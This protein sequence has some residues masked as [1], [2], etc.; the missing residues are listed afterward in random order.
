MAAVR[1]N[2]N[3]FASNL[4]SSAK[5]AKKRRRTLVDQDYSGFA[6]GSVI[7]IKVKN[8][9]TY[10][11]AEFVLSPSLNMIIGPNGTGKS[12]FVC[13]LCLGLAGSPQLL[14]RQKTIANF[15]KNGEESGV[16]EVTLKG[17]NNEKN[18]TIMREI[19]LNNKSDWY[20]NGKSSNESKV[21]GILN[22]FNIQLDNLCQF[23]PQEKVAD[24][25][26]LSPKD[27]LLETQRAIDLSLLNQ[28]EH[29]IEKDNRKVELVKQ[30][31][32]KREERDYLEK[33][34]DQFEEEAKK[35]EEFQQKK[36]EL[37]LHEKLIPYAQIQDLKRQKEQ[38]KA[39]KQAAEQE[40]ADYLVVSE[41]YVN[42]AISYDKEL[43]DFSNLIHDDNI[44]IAKFEQEA[45]KYSNQI[46]K[47]DNSK[48][49]LQAGISEFQ[50]RKDSKLK[51]LE[52]MQK[53]LKDQVEARDR[54]QTVNEEDL[55]QAKVESEKLYTRMQEIEDVI[56]EKKESS[57]GANASI[58]RTDQKIAKMKKELKTNDR[59]HILS[60][61]N[62]DNNNPIVKSA[63]AAVRLL[64]TEL[65]S[66]RAK[67]FEPA[68]LTV[69]TTEAAYA[70]Y[71]NALVDFTTTFAITCATREAYEQANDEIVKVK[72]INV[73]FRRISGKHLPPK[74]TKEELNKL[75]FDG[76]LKEFLIGPAPVIQMLCE[77]AF[78]HDVPVA[79]RPLSEAQINYLTNTRDNTGR[80]LFRK[81]FSGEQLYNISISK[82]GSKQMIL[83]NSS[84]RKAKWFS[85]GGIDTERIKYLNSLIKEAEREK[86]GAEA[87]LAP[88]AVEIAEHQSEKKELKKRL[89]A[90]TDFVRKAGIIKKENEKLTQKI[91]NLKDS[92]ESLEAESQKD[93]T[94]EIVKS[95]R[96]IR[97]IL[98]DKL[99]LL[100]RLSDLETQYN[101]LAENV[102]I[103]KVKKFE[104]ENRLLTAKRLSKS[105]EDHKKELQRNL[106]NTKRKLNELKNNKEK[107]RIQ[108]IISTY[109]KEE[110]DQLKNLIEKYADLLSEDKIADAIS[111]LNA[112]IKLLGTSSKSS[113]QNFEKI[114]TD[115]AQLIE[116][117]DL[118][119]VNL[120]ELNSEIT[121]LHRDWEPRL[122]ELISKIAKKFSSIFPTVGIAGDVRIAKNERYQEW[123]L[124]ILV[125]FREESDFKVLDSHTQ[126]GGER[127]V[128]TVYYM[129]SMQELTNSPFRAVDEINQGMDERNERIVHKHMVETAC[130]EHTSQYFL[131]T[132]KLL[133]GLY[134]AEN[135]RIHCIMAGPWTPNTVD[136]PDY[137]SLG[138]TSNY[139]Y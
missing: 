47:L 112:S 62:Y 1:I 108:K 34:K 42:A 74:L 80:L 6:T 93:Y 12:T 23:L 92:C 29:L 120:K 134:Y 121:K 129:I 77:E 11:T 38:L 28:H 19:Y 127:A 136:D 119:D 41:P 13:A 123:R 58:F 75:G 94:R 103:L 102:T 53:V 83:R 61:N 5:P 26:K 81:F 31:D 54:L 44:Q 124:E 51:E 3:S 66:L 137:L 65:S 139:L 27:L 70:N 114:K 21:K 89:E 96:K 15:I 20:V 104:V 22:G 25:A 105:F 128:S 101:E 126:S 10:S 39:A 55:E 67:V 111:G 69:T 46:Q 86:S 60:D 115:L 118:Y 33:K 40:L 9:V 109:T 107:E 48:G 4:I 36:H 79:K 43:Q 59:V 49:Q 82:Y 30:Y 63:N 18:I 98:S 78:V 113:I 125:K 50:K 2:L 131:I 88:I 130:L 68:C 57:E 84:V 85:A 8:F 56:T 132:P 90:A 91:K 14:G 32:A 99:K 71:L 87:N 133:T 45:Q 110:K 135:M 52:K 76:Y 37:N 73:P 138:E 95:E 7:R 72:R 35:Y 97:T 116:D 117:I 64:R 16:I 24:F 122:E 17:H 100:A 106:D